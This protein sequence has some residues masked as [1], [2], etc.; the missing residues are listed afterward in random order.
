MD[1]ISSLSPLRVDPDDLDNNPSTAPHLNDLVATRLNRRHVIQGGV[2]AL[3]MAGFGSLVSAAPAS[4]AAVGT[5]A[6][7]IKQANL[8][9]FEPV[10]KSTTA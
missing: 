5:A 8:L 3:A 2:G 1:R 7:G 4:P 10:G 6:G 9:D